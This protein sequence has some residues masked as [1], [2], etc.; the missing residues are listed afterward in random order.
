MNML[1]KVALLIAYCDK[2]EDA[3]ISAILPIYTIRN[4]YKIPSDEETDNS[5]FFYYNKIFI[6]IFC[7]S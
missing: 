3:D 4:K 6:K 5:C 1:Q 2:S 7:F